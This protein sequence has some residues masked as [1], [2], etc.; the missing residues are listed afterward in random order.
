MAKIPEKKGYSSK[1]SP[2]EIW[3]LL[4]LSDEPPQL[5]SHFDQVKRERVWTHATFALTSFGP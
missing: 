3:I 4:F 2:N 5:E 1:T